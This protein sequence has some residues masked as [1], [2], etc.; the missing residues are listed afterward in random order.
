MQHP[1]REDQKLSRLRL[2]S[3]SWTTRF[4][5][6]GGRMGMPRGSANA[7]APVPGGTERYNV[8]TFKTLGAETYLASPAL[9]IR[10]SAAAYSELR[11]QMFPIASST[12]SWQ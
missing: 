9:C 12:G 6:K 1:G 2:A 4:L 5:E 10:S 11:K 8:V 7:I 3:G